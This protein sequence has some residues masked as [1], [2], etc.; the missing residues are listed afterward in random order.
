[1][2]GQILE[3]DDDDANPIIYQKVPSVSQTMRTQ[4]AKQR[5]APHNYC[6]DATTN[7]VALTAMDRRRPTNCQYV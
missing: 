1:M 3:Y 2:R 4:P 7:V 6:L 5:Y